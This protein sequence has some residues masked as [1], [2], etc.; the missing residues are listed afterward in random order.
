[1]A[2]RWYVYM[3]RCSDDSLYI[4]CSNDVARRVAAHNAGRGARYTRS[5]R[6]VVLAWRRATK[7]HSGA[8]RLEAALKRL[9]RAVKLDIIEG[10]ARPPRLISSN[11]AS[12][13]R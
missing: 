7:D 3:V 10:L 1:M 13:Q 8:L 11:R 9:P 6:P 12:R 2:A 5:R 4:G